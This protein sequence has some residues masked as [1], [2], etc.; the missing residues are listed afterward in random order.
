MNYTWKK[1]CVL[2]MGMGFLKSHIKKLNPFNVY[3]QSEER[4]VFEIL[5]FS[6]IFCHS[7]IYQIKIVLYWGYC[8]H[9]T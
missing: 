7:N 1:G 6:E 8:V 5:R 9:I 2:G 4:C 3:L